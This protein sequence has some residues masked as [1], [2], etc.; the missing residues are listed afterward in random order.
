M[1]RLRFVGQMVIQGAFLFG[2][3][4]PASAADW[5]A[6]PA[7]NGVVELPAQEWLL[8][9]GPRSVRVLVHFPGGQR[10]RVTAETGLMLTLHNWGGTDCVGTAHP[11]A[12]ADHLNVVAL[13]VN[14]LQSGPED[15]IRGPEPYDFGYLQ[16]LDALRA[17][18]WLRQQLLDLQIRFDDGRIYATGGSGGGNVTLMAN[19]LAP[20]T[21]TC[22]IDMCGM[23][24][25][26]DDIAFNLPGGSDLN[27]RWSRD[28]Q[29]PYHLSRGQQELRFVGCAEHL[30]TMQRL[31]TAAKIV[32]VHGVEDVVCPFADA[33]EL[34]RRMQAW[35]LAVEPKFVTQADLDGQVFASAGH[36]LG[37]RTQIVFRTADRYLLR[38]SPEFLRRTAPTDFARGDEVRYRTSDGEFVISYRSGYPLGRFEPRVQPKVYA[39]RVRLTEVIDAAGT[40]RPLAT[41]AD[42]EQRR[43]Q[44]QANFEL[45]AGPLPG[46][47]FRVPLD[48]QITE[49]VVVG[50]ITRIKLS[51]Q[52]DPA[53]RVPA[54]LF[55]PAR[56]ADRP[57]PAV[58]CLHQTVPEGKAEPAGLAGSADLHY[59]LELA[60]DHGYVTL[61]PDYP[62]FG[63]H[64]YEFGDRSPYVSG[65]MKAIWDNLRALDLLQSR[66]E[67]DAASLGVLGHSLGGH[68]AIFTALF[69]ERLQAV[70]SS[71]GFCRFHRD[72]VPSWTGPRYMPRI[73]SVYQNQPDR[74]P[75]DF[76]ELIAAIAP[77][78]FY[79][80]AAEKD[81][82]FDVLGVRETLA[83]A[84]PIFELYG[85]GERLATDYP[86]VRHSFPQAARQRAYAFLNRWLKPGDGAS[87]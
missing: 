43:R 44:I 13:C 11:Q 61:A 59:A 60:R 67:V 39:D 51:Y 56:Q 20:R 55:L 10:E 79:A 19:K 28:P 65:T 48:V 76:P 21:F 45:V 72:D 62:S 38:T 85:T 15:S 69:D 70:V 52:S 75:F 66:P 37:D 74:V 7:Q 31:K 26:S 36:S 12:L 71:C 3:V 27:A 29:H 33:E 47:E 40:S 17:L 25:L 30:W 78:A 23:K 24:K 9:P 8:R 49:T 86:T 35:H 83:G 57:L 77:R 82:D 53:D 14:Y 4:L 73:A 58:L 41:T 63:E 54:Y 34:V 50:E 42:W 1:S 32:I 84:R 22:V 64:S 16:G 80:S 18:W 46:P 68:N 87:K 6:L 81:D 5:P 2:W